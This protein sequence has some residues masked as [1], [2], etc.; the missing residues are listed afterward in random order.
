MSYSRILF[1]ILVSFTIGSAWSQ[2]REQE[3]D[4]IDYEGEILDT[5]VTGFSA[6]TIDYSAE[7]NLRGMGSSGERLPFWM[8]KNQR[9]RVSEDSRFS[10]WI[11]GKAIRYVGPNSFL[12]AGAGILY[13]D[14]TDQGAVPD[15]LYLH[16]GN[17]WIKA[18][19]GRKQRPTIYHGLSA[20]NESILWS[21]NARP[22][23]GIQL[24]TNGPIFLFGE[25]GIG[26]EASWNEYLLGKDRYLE[27]ARLHH[28]NFHLLYRTADGLQIRA[29]FRHFGH[30]GGLNPDTGEERPKNFGAYLDAVTLRYPSQ[31]HLSSYEI[32]ISRT[33]DQFRLELLYN[34]ISTD[35][36]GRRFGNAPDGRY[37]LFYEA[38]EQDRLINAM[39][40]E[41]YYTH[42]QSYT[43]SSG[44]TDDYFNHWVYESGWTYK[45][46]V[47]GAPFFTYDR[48]AQEVINNKFTAHHFGLRGQY[49][50]LFRTFPYEVLL[51]YSRNAGT[52]ENR[53]SPKQNIF[54]TYLD[55]RVF[56]SSFDLN[57]QVAT[58]F[59][60]YTS[61]IYGAAVHLKYEL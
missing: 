50:T 20:S 46:R 56:Q 39:I 47:I 21:V 22:L 18:T 49:S 30:W 1:L 2:I 33:F 19:A 13:H 55:V 52:Y 58:E 4:P 17:Q 38:H 51:S 53:F 36:T 59:N 32:N 40:Y 29:G 14:G 10:G 23:P 5:T 35:L 43:S 54:S 41:F 34:H 27:D 60:T 28:K 16:Y 9:G 25:T 48:E 6:P 37:G 61:P 8:Y 15:E 57:I 42:N 31:N 44:T 24:S 7:V 11:T 3:E 12:E 26:F 45:N